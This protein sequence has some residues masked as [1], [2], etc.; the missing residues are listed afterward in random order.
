MPNLLIKILSPRLLSG[1]LPALLSAALLP[2]Y[3]ET[4]GVAGNDGEVTLIHIGDLH[5]HLIPRPNMREG[6]EDYGMQVGGVAYVYDEIK[7]IRSRH[8]H[9]LTINTGDTIQGSAEALYTSGDAM[10]KV[11]NEFAV[12][13]FAPGNWDFVYGTEK[14]RELF[15]GIDGKP[16]VTNWNTLAANLYYSTLYEFP[17]TRYAAMAGQRVVKPWSIFQVGE[18]R[19]ALIGLTADRGPQAVSTRVMEGFYL[20]PGEEE[21]KQAI[22]LL[23]EKEKVDLIVLISERGLAGNLE[24][25]ET[26]PGVDVVLSSDMHEETSQVL[27]AK[28]GTILIEEGQDGTMLGEL[29]IKVKKGK[30]ASWDFKAHRI[31]EINNKADAKIQAIVADI[32]KTFIK[33]T[34]FVPHVNPMNASVLRAPIDTVIGF[35]KKPLHR[36][37]F[38]DAKEM[39]AVVEGSSHDFLADAFKGACESD[40]GVI[41]GFR[42]GTH[43]A[44]GP[45]KLED[46]YHYIPI[47]PQIACG[48]IS[49]DEIRWSI[50]RGLQGSFTE[51]VGAWSGGWIVAYSGVTYDLDVYNEFGLRASNIRINGEVLDPARYY[52]VGG[53][54]YV[55]DPG[56]INRQHA[57]EITVLKAPDGDIVDATAVVAYYLRTL[58]DHTVDTDINRI[59]LLKPLPKPIGGSKEIQPLAGVIR[60]QYLFD[61]RPVKLTGSNSASSEKIAAV[62]ATDKTPAAK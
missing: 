7:N 47:G 8:K 20:T 27:V 40:V 52:R 14:F 16:P 49:G 26:I 38:S 33:G 37:N 24:L 45:I 53:Y 39:P 36:S 31:N 57:L 62:K 11:L 5:G 55:D 2:V 35:T 56:K 59:R 4:T 12:D 22:P 10:V 1:V 60:P 13:A 41:R 19:V 51:F 3:A 6:T 42:Y 23:R 9:T 46:I 25:V 21:L 44:P 54:W 50:E 17:E 18:M 43:V 30:V 58:P 61:A 32:R 29:T 48:L 28:S 15:A 34:D